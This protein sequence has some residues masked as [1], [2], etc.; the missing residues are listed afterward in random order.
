METSG[1][2]DDL[3]EVSVLINVAHRLLLGVR[4]DVEASPALQAILDDINLAHDQLDQALEFVGRALD[5]AD[6]ESGGARE[7]RPAIH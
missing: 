5:R 2:A 3:N 4:D 1:V 6:E 7:Q